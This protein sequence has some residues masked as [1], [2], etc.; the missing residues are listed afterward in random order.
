MCAIVTWVGR[1]KR[2][3]WPTV[4]RLLGELLV[5]SSCR[6]TDATGFAALDGRGGFVAD[7]Q[8]L[9][10]KT[11]VHKSAAWR[12]LS[13]PSCLVAH[14]RAA[15]HG[16]PHTGDNRNNHPFLA[17]DLAVIVNGVAPNYRAVA[18]RR[19][20]RLTSE[21]DS[22]VVLRLVEAAE[23]PADGLAA[24]L[25]DLDGGMAT[26]VLDVA[27]ETVWVARNSSR[28]LWLIRLTGINGT[29]ACS[30]REIAE[31][32]LHATYGRQW[33]ETVEML[34]PIT[35]YVIVSMT[36]TGRL[37]TV[38]AERKSEVSRGMLFP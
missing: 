3:Q 7:K 19:G 34:M 26:A 25:L 35:P 31:Y 32:A 33:S 22:E 12:A 15:T 9:P 28:P 4:H 16:S 21:C 38:S 6:G 27:A 30:T 36:G 20:L 17:P 8:P 29:F 13:S 2:G 1:A 11:F 23:S 18:S 10:S 37:M 5:A 14:C 24:A